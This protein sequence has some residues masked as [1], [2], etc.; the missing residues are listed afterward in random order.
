MDQSPSECGSK[1]SIDKQSVQNN[2]EVYS[3]QSSVNRS[4]TKERNLEID[5]VNQE[6][7]KK[8]NATKLESRKFEPPVF[9]PPGTS[10][11]SITQAKKKNEILKENKLLANR[12]KEVKSTIKR[13]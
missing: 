5:A 8:I 6:L 4:F 12:I 7:Q 3:K 13:Y 1:S 10:H 2:K 11:A 9:R